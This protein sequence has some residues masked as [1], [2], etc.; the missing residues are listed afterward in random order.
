MAMEW[1]RPVTEVIGD[2]LWLTMVVS[3]AAVML[4]WIGAADRHLLRGA[5]VLAARLPVHAAW[6]SG[7]AIPSFLL[8]LLV[9]YFGFVYFNANIG[10]LSLNT[11]T[12]WSGAKLIDMLKH[13]PVPASS[14]SPAW[15]R[16]SA[17]CAPIS[18]TSCASRTS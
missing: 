17:S 18:S 3:F 5:A 11:S 2:R 10:G 4:T 9:L 16:R 7:L 1:Q 13:L 14:G 6:L 8:G 12:P 15:P